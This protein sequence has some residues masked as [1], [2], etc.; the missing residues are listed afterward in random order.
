MRQ[1]Q[2]KRCDRRVVGL[3]LTLPVGRPAHARRFRRKGLQETGTSP[4]TRTNFWALES[5][6]VWRFSRSLL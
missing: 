5:N 2:A 6:R 3:G 4:Q 1:G